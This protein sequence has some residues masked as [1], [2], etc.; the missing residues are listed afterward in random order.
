M[1]N[2]FSNGKQVLVNLASTKAPRLMSAAKTGDL[3]PKTRSHEG[4]VLVRP[5]APSVSSP[6]SDGSRRR[7]R[8]SLSLSLVGAADVA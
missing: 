5:T 4:C 3:N 6:D 7:R 8:V 1:Y 2:Y